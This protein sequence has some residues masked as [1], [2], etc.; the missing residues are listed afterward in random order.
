MGDFVTIEDA[1]AYFVGD[2]FA[3]ENGIEIHGFA[4][5]Q[6][7]LRQINR[8]R[9][10]IADGNS[11]L[12]FD[13]AFTGELMQPFGNFFRMQLSAAQYHKVIARFILTIVHGILALQR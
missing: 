5:T 6:V 1:K 11:Y 3:A 8:L 7:A 4:G 2:K 13:T 9:N 12:V 10:H